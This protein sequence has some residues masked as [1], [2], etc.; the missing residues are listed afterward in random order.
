MN[1]PPDQT[2]EFSAENLLS[3]L[4]MTEPKYSRNS[5]GCSRSAG[6]GVQ[7]DHA[8]LLQVLA[9]LV[10]DDL[11]LVLRGDTGHQAGLLGLGDA[12]L[13]VGVLDVG[14]QVVPGGGLL[15]RGAHEV[16]DVVEVDAR[17]VGAP[18]R[19]GLALEEVQCLEA[20]LQ[21]PRGLVLQPGD[22]GD[23]IGGEAASRGGT[24]DVRV[25]P[26]EVVPAERRERLL[27][28]EWGILRSGRHTDCLPSRD[29]Y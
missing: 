8:L 29:R 10:V 14:G 6:V 28:G 9:D 1:D 4:G 5:S 19:H 27:L 3:P 18:A 2:A 25:G 11:G 17:Q 13:V 24:R 21:H 22:V 12:Q 16:L 23:D 26:A 15:L 7:E 20:E